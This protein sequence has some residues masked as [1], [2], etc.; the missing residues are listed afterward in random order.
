MLGGA[1]VARTEAL[2]A[3][4]RAVQASAGGVLDPF[5]S[6]L[7][8]RGMR[9]LA[10][11]MERASETAWTIARALQGHAR[12]AA[13]HYPGLAN[14]AGHAVAARQMALPDGRPCFG[15]MLSI[16][17][18]GGE[19]EA[20]RVVNALRL[21]RQATSLG[22]TESLAEHRASVEGPDTR[23][24]RGLLRLSIGLEHAS[25]LLDDLRTALTD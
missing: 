8:L 25:D 9:T 4:V 1:V 11:R 5:S 14:H 22:G 19:D 7:T 18:T 16:E 12:V 23:T 20:R 3:P 15:A 10:L 6:W 13:V 21:F 17:V 2:M 24:P